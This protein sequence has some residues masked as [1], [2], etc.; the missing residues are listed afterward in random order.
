M[1]NEKI[2]VVDDDDETL[3]LA[4]KI[5]VNEGFNVITATNGDEAIEII[6][7]NINE[8]PELILLDLSMPKKDGFEVCKFLKQD[9]KFNAI[10]IIIFTGTIFDESRERANKLGID[11]YITKPFSGIELISIIKEKLGIP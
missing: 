6:N 1:S 5:L 7:K 11:T 4:K 8:L 2:L 10:K 9:L 3:A